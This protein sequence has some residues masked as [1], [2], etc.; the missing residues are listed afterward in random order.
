MS[1]LGHTVLTVSSSLTG[2]EEKTNLFS[3][4]FLVVVSEELALIIIPTVHPALLQTGDTKEGLQGVLL[5]GLTGGVVAG[6]AHC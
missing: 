6:A 3:W 5:V 2:G 1:C 4:T